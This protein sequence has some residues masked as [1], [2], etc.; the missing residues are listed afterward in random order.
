MARVGGQVVAAA[1]QHHS[2]RVV[3]H[4]LIRRELPHV[5]KQVLD[6]ERRLCGGMLPNRLR[7]AAGA[8]QAHG[9]HESRARVVPPRVLAAVGALACQL[10]LVTVRE[11][12]TGPLAVCLGL[13]V[14][15]PHHWLVLESVP[16]LGVPVLEEVGRVPRRVGRVGEEGLEV[17]ARHEVLVDPERADV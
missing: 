14:A 9:R 2:A 11:A 7:A 3:V 12:P 15:D 1:A 13:R 10:P 17:G 4:K 5:A 16:V 6:A 8:L